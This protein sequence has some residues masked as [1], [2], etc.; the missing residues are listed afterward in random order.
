MT[1]TRPSL[2]P[3]AGVH[4]ETIY[5][6]LNGKRGTWS[7]FEKCKALEDALVKRGWTPPSDD[8]RTRKPDDLR[9]FV[10]GEIAS[11]IKGDITIGGAVD[12]VIAKVES[13]LVRSPT[14]AAD[15]ERRRPFRE[16]GQRHPLAGDF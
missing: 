14:D 10:W 12:A 11:A 2:A 13:L 4:D 15:K 9:D 16:R 7:W 3:L 8:T 5:H 1:S 6:V